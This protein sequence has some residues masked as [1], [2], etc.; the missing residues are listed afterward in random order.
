VSKQ[1]FH[2]RARVNHIDAQEAQQAP[3]VVLGEFLVEFAPAAVLFDSGASHSFIATN[4]VE[5]HGI[6]TAPLEVPLITRTPGSDLLCHLKCSHVR[7]LLSGVVFLADLAVIPSQGIDVILGM[8]WLS[9]H[10]GIIGCANKTVLLTYHQGK[11]V[12]CQAQPATQDPMVF[13]FSAESIS[14]VEEF[15][16]VFPEELPG[17]PPEREVE[18]YID[19]FPGTAPIA[20]RP[21]RMAP[22]ELAELKTQIA[23]LLQRGFIRPSSSPWGAL[24]L[25]V[26]KKDGSMR[27]CIDYRSLNEV[28][29]KNKYPLPRIDDL[30][31]QL[32]GAQY[33]SKIDLRSG[34]HQ[35]RVKEEDIQKTAFVT[36]YGQYEFTVMPFGLT[37]APAF[38]MNLMNKIFMKELDKFVV[39]FID[40]ILVYSKDQED[41]GLRGGYTSAKQNFQPHNTKNYCGYRSWNYH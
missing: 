2:N 34:Y 7:I 17:M 11:S 41:V 10:N 19:L 37:N 12:S 28:T 24:V 38:F 5:K 3:G 35:L 25:F 40:D 33:F 27:M 9:R 26:T 31:D 4:F 6:P 32:Q 21:Y 22:T 39:V 18:F 1:Q 29:I 14:V 13:S 23:E 20:K 8:D 36:R 15:M 16:D 30:F